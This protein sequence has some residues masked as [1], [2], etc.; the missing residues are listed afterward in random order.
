M[1]EPSLTTATTTTIIISSG[2]SSSRPCI[3]QHWTA[4]YGDTSDSVSSPNKWATRCLGGQHGNTV[5]FNQRHVYM[6]V[7][8][9]PSP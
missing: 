5:L 7:H 1:L 3:S 2:S 4:V 8:G 6:E 9:N